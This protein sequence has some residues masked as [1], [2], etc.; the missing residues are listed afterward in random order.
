[1]VKNKQKLETITILVIEDNP[2]D[3]RLIKEY[4]KTDTSANYSITI[5]NTLAGSLKTLSG[6]K[7]DVVFILFMKL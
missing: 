4:L 6:K 2:G 5:T 7:F 3:A 1:M